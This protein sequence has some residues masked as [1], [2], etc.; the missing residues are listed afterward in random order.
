[1]KDV[2]QGYVRKEKE[3]SFFMR[4]CVCVC[5]CVLERERERERERLEDKVR[6]GADAVVGNRNAK[7]LKNF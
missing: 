2:T 1:M 7:S 3:G 4:L 5:V 6:K